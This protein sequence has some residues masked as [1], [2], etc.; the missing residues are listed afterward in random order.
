MLS[1]HDA[2]QILS[3][4]DGRYAAD[5]AVNIIDEDA[6]NWLPIIYRRNNA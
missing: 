2:Q 5:R 3:P 4:A 1:E 6:E